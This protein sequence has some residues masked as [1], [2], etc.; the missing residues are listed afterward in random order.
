MGHAPTSNL[1][2]FDATSICVLAFL[3]LPN[4]DFNPGPL[5]PMNLDYGPFPHNSAVF[6]DIEQVLG[7]RCATAEDKAIGIRL[8]A[9]AM[10][11]NS[12]RTSIIGLDESPEARFRCGGEPEAV[13][14]YGPF[15]DG[16]PVCLNCGGVGPSG[17]YPSPTD[18]C[19]ARCTDTIEPTAVPPDPPV[20][21]FCLARARAS[22]NSTP[23]AAPLCLVGACSDGGAVLPDFVDPRRVPEPILWRDLIGVGVS[24]S[25]LTRSAATTGNFDAGAASE[26]WITRGDGYVEF[27]AG[28]TNL[29]HVAGFSRIP[30]GCAFPCPDADPGLTDIHFG[31]SLNRDGLFYVIEGG[32][33]VIGPGMNG[34]FGSY[35]AGERFRVTLLDNA[36][37]TATVNYSR[38][39]GVCTPGIPCPEAIFHTHTG[40]ATY[41]LRVEASFRETAATLADV[42]VVRIRS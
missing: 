37:G 33:L 16:L 21:A 19:V 5:P 7:R 25:D 24:G 23:E 10:A 17:H 34:S 36:D 11:L 30:S 2:W 15:P 4:C 28:E 41:P 3:V 35:A 13:I 39:T 40:L 20:L 32:T 26:Q 12:G 18:V 42:R 31:I 22:A 14:F 29:S 1:T 38:L 27:S 8:A 6:C 9:A